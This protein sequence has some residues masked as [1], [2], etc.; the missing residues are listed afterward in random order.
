MEGREERVPGRKQKGNKVEFRGR[1]WTLVARSWKRED[2]QGWKEEIFE[3]YEPADVIFFLP[4]RSLSSFI[5]SSIVIALSP[6]FLFSSHR[7][8]LA[9]ELTFR[10]G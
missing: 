10:I 1:G 6:P 3:I 4:L 8:L 2:A 5:S 9:F 7:L